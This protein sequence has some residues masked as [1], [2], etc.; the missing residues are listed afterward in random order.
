MAKKWALKKAFMR[1]INQQRKKEKEKERG[2]E[3]GGG[4]ERKVLVRRLQHVE[5]RSM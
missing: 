2:R 3:G 4:G 5:E 1:E